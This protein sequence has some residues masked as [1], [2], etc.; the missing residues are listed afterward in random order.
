MIPGLG[1]PRQ[2]A[3][4]LMNFGLILTTAFMVHSSPSGSGTDVACLRIL[5]LCADVEGS[6]NNDGFAVPNRRRSF[7]KHGASVSERGSSLVM[8]QEYFPGNRRGRGRRI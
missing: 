2:A 5:I 3:A 7:G 4:Q 6:L 1:N 8:E